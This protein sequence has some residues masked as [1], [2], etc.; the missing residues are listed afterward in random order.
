VTESKLST[1]GCAVPPQT[2][3]RLK[4]E[5]QINTVLNEGRHAT[6]HMVAVVLMPLNYSHSV[7]PGGLAVKSYRT[8]EIP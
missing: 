1:D 6:L 5:L 7:V 3:A 4:S 8:R 2:L